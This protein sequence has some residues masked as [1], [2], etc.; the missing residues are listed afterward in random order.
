MLC[1]SG[2]PPSARIRTPVRDVPSPMA[3]DI[4]NYLYGTG[5]VQ[6]TKAFVSLMLTLNARLKGSV[7]MVRVR[8]QSL[9]TCYSSLLPT[10]W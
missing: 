1:Q 5:D 9:I 2:S 10:S 4:T 6:L 8:V 3:S 7:K